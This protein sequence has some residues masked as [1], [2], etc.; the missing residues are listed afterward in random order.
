[1]ILLYL[2]IG[3]VTSIIGALPLGASNIVVINTTIK[4]NLKQAMKIAFAA[5][6]AEVILSYYALNYNMLVKD[7]FFSNQWLQV[8]IAILLLGFGG[9]LFFKKTD[10][11]KTVKSNNSFLKS[12]YSKGFL[13][14]LLN[15]PVLVYWLLVY[16]IIN[17]NVAML[18][19]KSSVLVLLLFFSG[20]YIGKVVT[21]Y[22]YGRFSIYIQQKFRNI[23]FV[24]NRITGSLLFSV[25]ILQF[26][27]LYF[28]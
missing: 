4:Q 13:L 6:V 24:I 5:G 28:I 11:K 9:L 16:G 12:K 1:M 8:L 7:F 23:N 20:V 2:L 17:S 15:P 3:L 27:K 25:G 18:S 22:I 26:V 19:V 14:G 21:L 10:S